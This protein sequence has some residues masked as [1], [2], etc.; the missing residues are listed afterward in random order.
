MSVDVSE[1]LYG[2]L[3]IGYRKKDTN[4]RKCVAPRER[5][6]VTDT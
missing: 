4:I 6:A 3:G 1:K 5:L 2:Q